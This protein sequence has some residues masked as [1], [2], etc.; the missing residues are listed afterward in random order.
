MH[1]GYSQSMQPAMIPVSMLE[2]RRRLGHDRF[3]EV[4]EGMLH[5]VPAPSP[6]HQSLERR[7]SA[8]LEPIADRRSLKL[9]TNVGVYDPNVSGHKSYRVPD[10][11]LVAREHISARGIEGQA[12]LVVEI[13]SPDDESR[14]KLPYYA[15]V[16]VR[17]VWLLDPRAHTLE[18]FLGIELAATS[19][20]GLELRVEGTDLHVR[21]AEHAYTVDIRDIV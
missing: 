8:A 1:L 21:D 13:L 4:W 9:L 14:D 11:V 6:P 20:L 10:I 17:E 3:D 7:L 2:E 18:V 5:M 15:R 19:S 12:E 16:G